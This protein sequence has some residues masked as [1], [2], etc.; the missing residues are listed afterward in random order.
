MAAQSETSAHCFIERNGKHRFGGKR[1]LAVCGM[2]ALVFT[3]GPLN[4]YAQSTALLLENAQITPGL[5]AQGY[6]ITTSVSQTASSTSITYNVT[7]PAGSSPDTL[8]TIGTINLE[9]VLPSGSFITNVTLNVTFTGGLEVV[10][11]GNSPSTPLGL[12]QAAAPTK[13]RTDVRG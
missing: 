9:G 1:Y 5:Q 13:N 7:P 6:V 8:T 10:G 3:V 11:A 12:A 2:L 4:A